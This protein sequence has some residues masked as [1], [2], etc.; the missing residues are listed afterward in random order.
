M[1]LLVELGDLE[2]LPVPVLLV[3]ARIEADYIAGHIPGAIHLDTFEFS[4]EAT[5]R[6]DFGAVE[7]AWREMLAGAGIS[8]SGSVVFYD[9]GTENRASRP[10]LMLHFLGHPSSRVLH[11][12]MTAWLKRGELQEAE[13]TILEPAPWRL[14][15]QAKREGLVIGIDDVDDLVARGALLL[16]VRDAPEFEGTKNMQGNPRLGRIPGAIGYEWSRLLERTPQIDGSGTPRNGA[17]VLEHLRDGNELRSELAALGVRPQVEDIVVYC[18]K[19]HR[20][21]LVLVGLERLGFSNLHVYAGSFR[22][23]SRRADHPVEP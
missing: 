6:G 5:G 14:G 15:E 4:N 11:G 3:D 1:T 9:I 8:E 2:S 13:P 23:W 17:E 19:S 22:E 18:Q 12:G 10:A 7:D 20:A 21:S 16:D